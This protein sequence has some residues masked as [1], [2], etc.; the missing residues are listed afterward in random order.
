MYVLQEQQTRKQNS[1]HPKKTEEA[2]VLFDDC[3]MNELYDVRCCD[4]IPF[5]T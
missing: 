2:R 1:L 5:V 4:L 3:I